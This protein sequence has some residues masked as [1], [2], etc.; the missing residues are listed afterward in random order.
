[1]LPDEGNAADRNRGALALLDDEALRRRLVHHRDPVAARPQL[2][3]GRAPEGQLRLAVRADRPGER[4][5]QRRCRG[6]L[7]A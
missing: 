1:M 5:E 6:R 4:P 2:L 7:A 3:H